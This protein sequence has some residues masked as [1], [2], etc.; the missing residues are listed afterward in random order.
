MHSGVL[1]YL[2]DMFADLRSG[3][4]SEEAAIRFV[5]VGNDPLGVGHTGA[6]MNLLENQLQCLQLL[7]FCQEIWLL[8][9]Q[10]LR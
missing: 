3:I 7:I 8:E 5:E 4:N 2:G 6:G 1:H 10:A 9:Q